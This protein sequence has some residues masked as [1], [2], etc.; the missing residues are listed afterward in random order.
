MSAEDRVMA[1]IEGFNQLDLE[2]VLSNFSEQ[3][4]YH[5]MPMEA[6]QGVDAIRGVL[7]GFL[8]AASEVQWDVLNISSNG[9][10][11]LTERVDKFKVNGTWIELPVMGT[12]EVADDKITVWR[13]YFDLNQFQT[14]FQAAMS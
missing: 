14:Q 10:I 8:G 7:N 2:A 9:G 12:F 11:V 1:M 6:V 5:N 13:D 3:A 4:V